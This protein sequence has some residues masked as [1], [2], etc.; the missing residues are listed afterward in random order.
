M[1]ITLEYIPELGSHSKIGVRDSMTGLPLNEK[2]LPEW[3]RD[4]YQK[5][6]S[7]FIEQTFALDMRTG[8]S[9]V[10]KDVHSKLEIDTEL[11]DNQ[12]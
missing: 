11:V 2:N 1:K 8:R 5:I 4:Y 6:K 9:Y 3:F 12:K 10:A 7:V